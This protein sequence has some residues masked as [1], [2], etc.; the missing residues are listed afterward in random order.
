MDQ[1]KSRNEVL[2]EFVAQGILSEEQACDIADAPQWSFSARELI[3]YLAALIIAVGVIRILAIAL[4]DASEG[5]IVTSLY[6]VAVAAGFGSWKLSSGSDIRDRFSEV[7][8]LAALGCAGGATAVLLSNTELRGEFIGIMLMSAALGWGV[9]RCRSSRFA[10]TVALCVGANGVAIS[11]GTLIDSDQ[12]WAAGVLMVAS[13]LSLA[14]VGTQRVGAPYFARAVGSLFVVIG[15][16]TLG[17]DI[18]TGR[19]IPIVTGIALFA[20]GTKFLASETLVA[21]A[22]CIV[23]G[24]VMTVNQS[25]NNDMA[26]GLVIIGTGVVMLIVL[27]AQ[28]KRISNRRELGAPAA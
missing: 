11:L 2:D 7:L 9:Y 13:G 3:T 18:S 24:V 25:I 17:T 19:V 5:A 23:T 12:A 21:G 10:G 14:V 28:M 16:I 1:R 6:I 8:E 27:T 4:Q 20:I 22:F 15:S 26:Q